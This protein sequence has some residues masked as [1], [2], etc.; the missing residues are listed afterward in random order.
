MKAFTVIYEFNK[1]AKSE[2]LL[3]SEEKDVYELFFSR[4]DK[5]DYKIL[6]IIEKGEVD[7]KLKHF[8]GGFQGGIET[9]GFS[10]FRG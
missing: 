4:T 3:A 9:D 8:E 2:L 6:S 7:I 10:G 5:N 1:R